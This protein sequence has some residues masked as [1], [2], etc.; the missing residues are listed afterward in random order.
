MFEENPELG[1]ASAEQVPELD[2]NLIPM[3][4]VP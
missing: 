4:M 2:P 3:V 1:R